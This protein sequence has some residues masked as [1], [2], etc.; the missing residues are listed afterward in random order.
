M[1]APLPPE[2]SVRARKAALRSEL[3]LRLGQLS[4]DQRRRD[5]AALGQRLGA[6][7]EWSEARAVLGFVALPSEP[8]LAETLGAAA[9]RGRTVALPRW[10]PAAGEYR[11]ALRP[12]AGDLVPGPYGV[13]EPPPSSPWLDFERLDLVLV[14]GLAFD[15]R[16]RRLGR[17][18]GHFDRLLARASSACRWGVAF[19]VQIVAEVPA[20]PH[21][22]NVHVLVT[23]GLWMPVV[24]PVP[25]GLA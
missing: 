21:D 5:S 9:V 18:R 12:I 24:P 22:I 1:T 3:R 19:D 7:R 8:D 25:A 20:E 17:G 10:D 13:L 16:G 14:P 2:D 11:P 23:P 15:R 6:A 4:A